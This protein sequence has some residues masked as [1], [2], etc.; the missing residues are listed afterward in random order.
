M[1]TIN[2][3]FIE[4]GSTLFLKTVLIFLG[5]G[6]LALCFWI[7]FL[8]MTSTSLGGYKYI[9]IGVS[10]SFIPFLYIFY[11]SYRLLIYIDKNL[12]L[13]DA[14]VIALKKIMISA[15]IISAMY[16]LGSPFVFAVAEEDD[17]PGV[18]LINLI[19]IVVPFIV[20]VFS[21]ILQK[22]L[23]NA[24]SYKSENELTI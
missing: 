4:R 13:T 17:A 20:G 23:I 9:L 14:S 24:I 22:L 16:L 10:L 8:I 15:F 2:S 12:S 11:Q 6:T 21:A 3:K 19:L 7:M 1:N 18:V 5:L